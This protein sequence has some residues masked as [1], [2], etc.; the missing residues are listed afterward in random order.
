METD[1][2]RGQEASSSGQNSGVDLSGITRGAWKGSDVTQAKID[3]LYR[4]RRIP[5]EVSY[6]LP[7]D[8]TEPAKE[9]FPRIAAEQRGPCRKRDLDTEDPDPYVHWTDLKMGR[10]HTSRPDSPSASTIPQVVERA[11]PIQAEVGREFLEKLTSQGKKK[12]APASEAGP[13]EAPPAKRPRQETVGGKVVSKKQYKKRQMPVSSGNTDATTEDAGRVEPLAPTA[14]KKKKKDAS[15]SPSKTA[16]DSSEPASSAPAKDAPEAPAPTKTT[17]TPPPPATSTGKPAASKPT[18][19]ESG[20]LTAQQLAAVMT[21][22]TAPSSGS[23]T[24]ALHAGRAAVVAGETAS[25]Q[26]GRITEFQRGGVELGHLLDYAEKWNQADLTPAM[27]GLSKDKLPIVDPSGPRS[28]GQHF[29]RLRRRAKE[30]DIAW[31]DASANVSL[32]RKPP[33]TP[34]KLSSPLSKEQLITAHRGV[35]DQA[36][37]AEL[38]HAQELKEAKAAAEAKLDDTLKECADSTA[39][40]RAELEEESGARKAAQDRIA[41]LEAEQKE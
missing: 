17:S 25:A 33:S 31:H 8:E 36:I 39:V 20:K 35:K 7:R 40:L 22:A 38:R 30:F 4:S 34:S 13:S 6:R 12:K 1:T 29:G 2:G 41:L 11:V 15:S 5:A 16:P 23:Q 37:Q 28:T 10:T 14:P 19:R 26:V 9:R 3:W 21:A 24:L 18:P 32:F 27:R